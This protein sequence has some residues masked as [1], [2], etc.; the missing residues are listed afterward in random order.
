[1]QLQLSPSNFFLIFSS[2]GCFY[3]NIKPIWKTNL[4]TFLTSTTQY[5][6]INIYS[7]WFIEYFIDCVSSLLP[8]FS[9]H[10]FPTGYRYRHSLSPHLQPRSRFP[11]NGLPTSVHQ[12]SLDSPHPFHVTWRPHLSTH[13][14]PHHSSALRLTGRPCPPLHLDLISSSA[15][16]IINQ[17]IPGYHHLSVRHKVHTGACSTYTMGTYFIITLYLERWPSCSSHIILIIHTSH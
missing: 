1:M 17:P 2:L 14:F 5:I 13:L 10:S 8:S 7:D 9:L 15:R 16:Q 11:F 12:M 6:S 4:E 3:L